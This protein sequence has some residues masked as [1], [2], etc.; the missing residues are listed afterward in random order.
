MVDLATTQAPC[1][2]MVQQPYSNIIFNVR[3]GMKLLDGGVDMHDERF[4]RCDTR[5]L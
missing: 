3:E 1:P 5:H 2:R 4:I